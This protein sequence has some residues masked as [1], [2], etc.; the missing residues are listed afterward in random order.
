L[1]RRNGHPHIGKMVRSNLEERA[2]D[3]SITPAIR[4]VSI[5]QA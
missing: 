2:G 5:C 3:P 1:L 4:L